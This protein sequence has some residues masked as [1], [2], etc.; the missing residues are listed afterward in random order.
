MLTAR[1][2]PS[3]T[4]ASGSSEN[5]SADLRL[6]VRARPEGHRG[7]FRLDPRS[8]RRT[9]P[10]PARSNP[11]APAW[12][13]RPRPETRPCCPQTSRRRG[14]RSVGGSSRAARGSPTPGRPRRTRPRTGRARGSS[15]RSDARGDRSA[16]TSTA[17]P[18]GGSSPARSRASR[19][20]ARPAYASTAAR[21][22]TSPSASRTAGRPRRVPRPRA[23]SPPSPSLSRHGRGH[24]PRRRGPAAS[25]GAGASRGSR[26][27]CSQPARPAASQRS[28]LDL[29]GSGQILGRLL[30]S[31]VQ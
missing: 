30:I 13:R 29:R 9:A 31:A 27:R 15:P 23:R 1:G 4:N 6:S 17:C 12:R 5:T 21:A 25:R 22:P 26:T 20:P 10:A 24:P 19:R 7:R 14:V 3:G 18:R 2:G 28:R 16:P 11:A 8:P